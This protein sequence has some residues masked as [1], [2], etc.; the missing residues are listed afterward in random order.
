MGLDQHVV[1]TL[2]SLVRQAYPDWQSFADVRTF[3]EERGY[4]L[5]AVQKAIGPDGLLLESA[6]REDLEGRAF[7]SFYER[8][9]KIAQATNMLYLSTPSTGDLN[10]LRLAHDADPEVFERFCWALLDLLWGDG[11]SPERLGRYLSVL[12]AEDLP[13]KWTFPTYFLFLTHPDEDLF[14]KTDTMRRLAK[15]LKTPWTAKG[16]PTAEEYA[17]ILTWAHDLQDALQPFG[18]QDMI[19][20]QS[21]LWIAG[22]EL[23]TPT[24]PQ[25]NGYWKIAPGASARNWDACR[26]GGFIGIGWEALGD[27]GAMSREEFKTAQAA[28]VDEYDDW[29]V[30]GTEQVW[31]FAHAI[32]EGDLIVANKGKSEVV[33]FGKVT[34]PYEY[35]KGVEHG[36]HLPVEWFDVRLRRLPE[37]R[38]GWMRTLRSMKRGEFDALLSLP[39][40]ASADVLGP[41]FDKIFAD[42]ADADQ[43]LDLM[44]QALGKLGVIN[45]QDERFAVTL[46]AGAHLLTLDFGPW[47][48]MRWGPASK[49]DRLQLAMFADAPG[50]S[51]M[52]VHFR[53]KQKVEDHEVVLRLMGPGTVTAEVRQH[54]LETARLVGSTFAH[55]GICGERKYHVHEVAEAVFDESIRDRLL[56]E[57]LEKRESEEGEVAMD[58]AFTPEALELLTAM[59]E[60]PTK[61]FNAAHKDELT[62]CVQEP[63]QDLLLTVGE[64]VA[65][66]LKQ[67]LETKKRLFGI[68]PKNDF[69]RGGAWAYYWG[70]FYPVGGKKS[71]GCQLYGFLNEE[72]LSYGF[73]IGNY[74]SEDRKRFARNVEENRQAIVAALGDTINAPGFEFGHENESAGG[75]ITV[76][77]EGLDL[78]GWLE[79]GAKVAPNVR[80]VVPWHEL[81]GIER[82]QLIDDVAN[83][84]ARLF[85]LV[86]LATSDDP[87]PAIRI[88]MEGD[89]EEEDEIEVNPPYSLDDLV[90]ETSLPKENLEAWLRAIERKGQAILYGPPGTGKTYVAERLAKHLVAEG[91]GTA[92][93]VQFHP[94]YAYEDFMQGMRP[95]ARDGGGLDYPI[96]DGRFKQF[97]DQAR[98]RNGLSVLI[99]DEVNRANLARVFGEL[100]YLL[101]YRDKSIPLAAGGRFSIPANVRLIGTM[102]TADRSIA[103][104]DHALRRRFAFLPLYP[105]YQMLADY[106]AKYGSGYNP[107]KLVELL[108]DLNR[109]IGDHHYEVGTSF[110]M[111]PDI[112]DQLPDV[113]SME[114]EPY[115][116]EYFF[117]QRATVDSFRWDEVKKK[118]GAE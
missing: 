13:S 90:V 24:Q 70:A 108:K 80:V 56:T 52:E 83:A 111:R 72:G 77:N 8:F 28:A 102:N 98:G 94:A 41:P 1:D 87:M 7:T 58:P 100:M 14:V 51:G 78:A 75:H 65:P 29:T 4:K 112:A 21:L 93:L 25:A 10:A 85:P 35:L 89:I 60:D 79:Q 106:H 43:G 53:F 54:F 59:A 71:E 73:S 66:P 84:F 27:V 36:H 46:N 117:D 103:L 2:V 32:A 33:G 88:Y 26:E 107:A 15:E 57:G 76:G 61:S 74:A 49:P 81:L 95:K 12:A 42:R 64:R 63:V 17:A 44:A 47:C 62:K 82:D 38:H 34:G 20:V 39:P 69:G 22:S 99:I 91:T 31:H 45:N 11:S 101:E 110:F 37:P 19:D 116:E 30:S 55:H 6:L 50:T 114:I 86:L 115:L 5:E 67:A 105:D 96:M 113:W 118:L 68:F 40:D 23:G 109:K 18:V 92:E 16:S 9:K 48:V 104:V 97:C 3:E